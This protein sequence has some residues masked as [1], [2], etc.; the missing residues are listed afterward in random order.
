M[1][2]TT[3]NPVLPNS[4]PVTLAEMKLHLR[5]DL[6]EEDDLISGYIAA[7]RAWCEDQAERWFAQRTMI[8]VLD[9][10]PP[11]RD[12]IVFP[13]VGVSS[14]DTID[15]LGA[16]EQTEQ[17]TAPD[18]FRLSNAG[19]AKPRIVPVVDWPGLSS[20]GMP[21]LVTIEFT[22]GVPVESMDP[23]LKVAVKLI[24]AHFYANRE[25]EVT[26]T[27]STEIQ[28]GA[29]RIMAQLLAP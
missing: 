27:I 15:Y 17:L 29:R 16:D 8:G 28:L 3:D 11:G 22:A 10:F 1:M 26:G 9:S 19:I 25:A 5:V 20:S 12:P 4:E 23:R 14:V 13:R 7:A 18:N 6:A 21:D 24:A 2:R